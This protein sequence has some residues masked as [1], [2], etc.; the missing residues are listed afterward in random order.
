MKINNIQ[1]QKLLI[2]F[3]FVHIFLWTIIPSII[4]NNLHLD[5]I[6]VLAWGN[7][8]QLGYD[9]YPPVFPRFTELFFKVFGNQDWALFAQS[10][11]CCI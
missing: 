11:I 1:T 3:L 9:K 4:N 6:E 10:I 7:E 5:T 2:Y 8:L